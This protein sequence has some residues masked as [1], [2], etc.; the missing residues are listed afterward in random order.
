VV[1]LCG[2]DP[3]YVGT[4]EA[5]TL[6]KWTDDKSEIRGWAARFAGVTETNSD[7]WL[8]SSLPVA[9]DGSLVKHDE[10]VSSHTPQ[11]LPNTIEQIR[12][13]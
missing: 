9:V 3:Q 1:W 12:R 4:C 10:N 2:G 5:A 11:A 8:A 7:C 13:Y 6:R